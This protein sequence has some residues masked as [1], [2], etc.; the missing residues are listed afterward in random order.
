MVRGSV[1]ISDVGDFVL[2]LASEEG[3]SPVIKLLDPLGQYEKVVVDGDGE[4]NVPFVG[5]V[6]I[7]SLIFFPVLQDSDFVPHLV[8]FLL[9]VGLLSCPCLFS[10]V[11]SCD[12]AID[13]GAGGSFN[14]RVSSKSSQ[15]RDGRERIWNKILLG[16]FHSWSDRWG[17]APH[18]SVSIWIPD[19]EV[20]S[21][22]SSVD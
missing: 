20:R 3:Y 21:L 16:A 11:D 2:L 17:T 10:V 7:W 8:D 9:H 14:A 5:D 1:E 13:N 4:V 22:G 18:S 15:G 12:E 6:P 19:L